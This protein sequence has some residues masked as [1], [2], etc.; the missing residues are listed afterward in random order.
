MQPVGQACSC[1]MS[2]PVS[3]GSR[4]VAITG[5]RPK[6]YQINSPSKNYGDARIWAMSWAKIMSSVPTTDGSAGEDK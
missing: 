1:K 5:E 6:T 2:R 3:S 4:I